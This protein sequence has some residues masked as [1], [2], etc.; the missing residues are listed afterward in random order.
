LANK[1]ACFCIYVI[2]KYKVIIF[3]IKINKNHFL[4]ISIES[5]VPKLIPKYIF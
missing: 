5:P 4:S 1:F 2:V 3:I